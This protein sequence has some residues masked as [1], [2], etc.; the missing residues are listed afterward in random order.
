MN[1]LVS[2][3]IARICLV[4]V[5]LRMKRLV[6]YFLSWVLHKGP[7]CYVMLCYVMLCLNVQTSRKLRHFHSIIK[8]SW[9]RFLSTLSEEYTNLWERTASAI[10][11]QKSEEQC[12]DGSDR[13]NLT[14][15]VLTWRIGWAH[16]NARKC[17]DDAAGRQ[18][19]PCIIPQAV[20]TV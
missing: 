18:H 7:S 14:L 10:S 15:I 12:W 8:L 3:L 16:N 9:T 17:M 6:D 4:R 1:L 2:I 13:A 5:W 11:G 19:R 20:N